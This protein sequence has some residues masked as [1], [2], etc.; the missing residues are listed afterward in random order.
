LADAAW[1]ANAGVD[2][3]VDAQLLRHLAA[4]I[5]HPMA[6]THPEGEYLKGLMLRRM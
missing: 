1:A 6:I 5:D 2:A 3:G 4:G